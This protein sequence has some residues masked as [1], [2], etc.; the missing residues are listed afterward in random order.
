MT[1]LTDIIRIS[2]KFIL[3]VFKS[4]IRVTWL[5]WLLFFQIILP[6]IYISSCSIPV[7]SKKHP[8]T[9]LL[10]GD[11]QLTDK[12]SYKQSPGILLY[13][14]QFYSDLYM[15][16]NFDYILKIHDPK[17]V[18]FLGDLMDGGRE[19]QGKDFDDELSRF[20]RI[21]QN[22]NRRPFYYM[23]GNHDIGMGSTKNQEFRHI[24]PKAYDR[25]NTTFNQLNYLIQMDDTDLIVLDTIGLSSQ[26]DS[27]Y[28]NQ[29]MEFLNSVGAKV[30]KAKTRILFT[31]IPLYRPDNLKCKDSTHSIN[32]GFGN[33]YQNLVSKSTSLQ[34]LNLIRPSLV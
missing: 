29:S 17:Y 11:P 20:N 4:P 5:V 27:L 1:L 6:I 30:S 10:I 28:Y 18:L 33:Q 32:A 24:I 15:R 23:A 12:Y 16:V 21:F 7:Q 34:I 14:T 26:K 2:Y 9:F 8:H 22:Y 13:L 19:W 3:L 25:F 31:H